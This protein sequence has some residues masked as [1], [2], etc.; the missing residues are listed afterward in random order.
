MANKTAKFLEGAVAALALGVAA[1]MF[2]DT[3]KG[4]EIKKD[5]VHA[6]A[7]FYKYISPKI[8][9]V[10]KM[11]EKEYKEF[12]KGAV[13]QYIKSRKITGVMAEQLVKNVQQ[14]WNH[15]SSHLGK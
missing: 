12:M 15:F 6:T 3:K 11:G 2:L 10:K 1:K 8:K 7:D 5:V 13:G 14:S 4:K 9:K